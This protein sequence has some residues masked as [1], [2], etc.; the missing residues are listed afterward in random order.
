MLLWWAPGVF[1]TSRCKPCYLAFPM[2][3][4]RVLVMN[5]KSKFLFTDLKNRLLCPG[6]WMH[7]IKILEAE[8]RRFSEYLC[9]RQKEE[10][11]SQIKHFTETSVTPAGRGCNSHS[12]V[13]DTWKNR[14]IVFSPRKKYQQL[15]RGLNESW[16]ICD[17]EEIMMKSHTLGRIRVWIWEP[18]L[19]LTLN[20]RQFFLHYVGLT[21]EKCS[22][23]TPVPM[24]YH[25]HKASLI[26]GSAVIKLI[27]VDNILYTY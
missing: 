10:S 1:H 22:P 17:S 4:S 24:F 19:I 25:M 21:E 23:V 2:F 11:L 27:T 26:N 13:S 15:S 12:C 16:V 9:R 5:I 20:L 8:I 7:A 6:L 18:C 3:M 14:K